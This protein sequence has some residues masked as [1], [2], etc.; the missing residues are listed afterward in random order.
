MLSIAGHSMSTRTFLYLVVVG[1]AATVVAATAGSAPLAQV[2][3]MAMV[4][5]GHHVARSVFLAVGAVLL[6]ATYRQA[7]RNF[8]AK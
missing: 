6:A 5:S 4:A 7:I 3:P 2:E 8:R 1:M